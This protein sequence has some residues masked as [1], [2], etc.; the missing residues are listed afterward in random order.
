[1]GERGSGSGRERF[2]SCPAIEVVV[3]SGERVR[4]E[5]ASPFVGFVFAR[6]GWVEIWTGSVSFLCSFAGL[7]KQDLD[8]YG[9]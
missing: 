3:R 9:G 7:Y 2:G 1:M 4:V 8:L 5:E 6:P